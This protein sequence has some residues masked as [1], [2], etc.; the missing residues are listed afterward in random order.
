VPCR[1]CTRYHRQCVFNTPAE[2]SDRVNRLVLYESCA[3]NVS[4]LSSRLHDRAASFSRD[5]DPDSQRV[6]YMEQI[7]AHYMPNT[8]F[9]V[10]SLRKI[11]ED[12][13]KRHHDL[14]ESDEPPTQAEGDDLDDLAIDE[15]DFSIRAFSDNTTRELTPS[16]FLGGRDP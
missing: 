10:P 3:W 4:N 1:R 15:E 9:D 8:S 2:P 6:R 12:L 5:D 13:Q 7:L 16:V 14:S 11:A